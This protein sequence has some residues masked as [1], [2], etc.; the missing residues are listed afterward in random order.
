VIEPLWR[1][2]LARC[3]PVSCT[4]IG[5]GCGFE[6]R[7]W[8]LQFSCLIGIAFLTLGLS[9]TYELKLQSSHFSSVPC[10]IFF[11]KTILVMRTQPR[12]PF[13]RSLVVY[14]HSIIF[15]HRPHSKQRHQ[16]S[17]FQGLESRNPLQV[18]GLGITVKETRY[19]CVI[20]SH[21]VGIEK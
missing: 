14:L 12:S 11:P 17:P 1:N 19:T 13:S 6:S 21:T 5:R 9:H 3:F 8:F 7:Q 2:G 15:D 10:L 4:T 20:S 16:R 18:L